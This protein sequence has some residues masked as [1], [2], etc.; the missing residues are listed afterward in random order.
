MW[1]SVG[2]ARQNF[3]IAWKD[4]PWSQYDAYLSEMKHLTMQMHSRLAILVFPYEPQLEEYNLGHEPEYVMKPQRQINVLCRKY[5]VPC[6]DMFSALAK[7]GADKLFRD[8]I[9]LSRQGHELT[10]SLIYAFLYEHHL[11]SH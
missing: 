11:L 1:F 5:D 7:N 9:H 8:G 2:S 3:N 6:L 4:E 10:A